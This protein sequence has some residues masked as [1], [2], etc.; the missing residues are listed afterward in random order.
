MKIKSV[1][2][3]LFL[4]VGI[5]HANESRG[6]AAILALLFG[7]QVASENFNLSLEL[8]VA[9]PWFTNLDGTDRSKLGINFGIGTNIKL[10]DNWF[11]CPNAYFLA[12]RGI[13]LQAATP[14]SANPELN[15]LFAN[16]ETAIN[17]R[18]IDVPVFLHYQ[19]DNEKFRFGVAPQIS[20][21]S[22]AEAIYDGPDGEFKEDLKDEMSSIDYGFIGNITYILG[23]AHKG[24]GV[25]LHLRYYQGLGSIFDS[26][27]SS[28]DV[29]AQYVS[30]H[31]SLPFI[32][33]EL[34]AKNLAD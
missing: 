19:T 5:F 1:F 3:S 8:G 15:M 6:Q 28:E 17:L 16:S 29:R 11:I 18:Y 33:D 25:H 20:F 13:Q 22:N 34:A 26:G 9:Q 23:K 14:L 30:L 24:R 10:S 2:A 21:L 31:L 7:D 12:N 4:L 27:F 32:T